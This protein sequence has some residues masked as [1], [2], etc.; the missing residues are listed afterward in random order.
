MR[1]LRKDRLRSKGARIN[2]GD[3]HLIQEIDMD[4]SSQTCCLIASIAAGFLTIGT[5]AATQASPASVTVT[6]TADQYVVSGR[7]FNT[8]KALETHLKEVKPRTLRV[9]ACGP[10]SI[11]GWK[12]VVHRFRHLPI[13]PRV[14]DPNER[15]CS[16]ARPLAIRAGSRAGQSAADIDDVE[17]DRYWQ[18]LIP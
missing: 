16:S 4:K 14:L 10:S 11:R 17:V 6:T 9:Q 13:E 12:A 3:P 8:L 18:E 15:E 5:A 2:N 1:A 7:A